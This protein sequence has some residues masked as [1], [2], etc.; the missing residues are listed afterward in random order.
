M[1]I[2]KKWNFR[3]IP[4]SHTQTDTVFSEI[5]FALRNTFC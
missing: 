1:T 4:K 2:Q 3:K 5:L